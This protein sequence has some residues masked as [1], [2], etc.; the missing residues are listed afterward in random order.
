MR[1]LLAFVLLLSLPRLGQ[2]QVS[3]VW[4]NS[5]GST[6]NEIRGYTVAMPAGGYLLLSEVE[7]PG[8]PPISLGRSFLFVR[9]NA[10]GDTL[11]T[12][13]LAPPRTFRPY[14]SGLVVD[15]AGNVLVT[16]SES[17]GNGNGF[18]LKLT[19]TCDT[20]WTKTIRANGPDGVGAGY[21]KVIVAQDGNYLCGEARSFSVPGTSGYRNEVT[22][23][24][25]SAATGNRLWSTDFTAFLQANNFDSNATYV[26][27]IVRPLTNYSFG[28]DGYQ[29]G[30]PRRR[31]EGTFVMSD[32]NGA[33]SRLKTRPVTGVS[34][35][36]VAAATADGNVVV[37]RRQMAT[38]LTP[39][40][41]TLWHTVVPRRLN[42]DWDATSLC[43]DA[44]GN[45][46]VAANSF[47]NV[48]PGVDAINVHFI[49]F[50]RQTGQV[51]NDTMLYRPGRTWVS[52][53]LRAANG[54]LVI[55][56][57]HDPGFYGGSDAY[58]AEWSAFRL[59]AA[60]A[61]AGPLAA[62]GLQVYPNPA[63]GPA[64]TLRLPET[65]RAGGTVQVYDGLGR[66][67]GQVAAPPGAAT[68][69]LPLGPL[70]PGLYLLRYDG[71][72]G[73]RL[74]TRLVRE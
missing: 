73:T 15:G 14:A 53:V 65:N 34:I 49:R 12:K 63:A 10:V 62:E 46:V 27:F 42:R 36:P 58:L 52:T 21:G 40:G 59:L 28:I 8:S 37:G 6:R 38:K 9:T 22:I 3:L 35:F 69:A 68:V 23:G 72:D 39:L 67:H 31:V 16:G 13:A 74:T 4:D 30:P 17:S 71:R 2:A 57:W 18:W 29:N 25:F 43:E 41:D 48:G 24:K 5:Y 44:Q 11:W 32:A 56:G 55:G 47:F 50:R 51:V 33:I 54:N 1:Y 19:S 45:V 7:Y 66:R 26:S 60:R 61:G 64:A 20:I 70:P